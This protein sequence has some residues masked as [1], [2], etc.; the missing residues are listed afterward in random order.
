MKWEEFLTSNEK[1]E[2]KKVYI[3]DV[4]LSDGNA[5]LRNVPPTEVIITCNS[6]LP[7]NKKVY[8]SN[9][10]FRKLNKKGEPL[11]QIVAPFDNTGFR[12][13]SGTSVNVFETYEEAAQ[14]YN[15]QLDEIVEHYGY[16]VSELNKLIENTKSLKI[17]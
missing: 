2:G 15:K 10:H 14:K 6:E 11:K 4:R 3:V 8:Y 1:V 5:F 13:Y 7:K 16:R 17:I 9:Y 12:S